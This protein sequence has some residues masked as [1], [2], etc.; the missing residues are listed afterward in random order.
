MNRQVNESP[1]RSLVHRYADLLRYYN[2]ILVL[3]CP[4]GPA[5]VFISSH[6]ITG[7]SSAH[8]THSRRSLRLY[9]I[10]R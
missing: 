7:A 5:V 2:R 1:V 4:R 6:T 3:V 10:A 9:C 8:I